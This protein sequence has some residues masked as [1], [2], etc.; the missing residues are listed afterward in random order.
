MKTQQQAQS[1][2]ERTQERIKSIDDV[3]KF[4]GPERNF[5]QSKDSKWWQER[6]REMYELELQ[7]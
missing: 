6:K 4:G 5:A 3:K 2:K 7:K 1:R